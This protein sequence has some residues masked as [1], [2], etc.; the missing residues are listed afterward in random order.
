MK[1]LLKGT[2]TLAIATIVG[3][4][5]LQAATND[6]T[7]EVKSKK[8]SKQTTKG[9]YGITYT[10]DNASYTDQAWPLVE[11]SLDYKQSNYSYSLPTYQIVRQFGVSMGVVYWIN[12]AENY[13]YW[14]NTVTGESGRTAP[15]KSYGVGYQD[16]I[17]NPNFA[18]T[19]KGSETGPGSISQDWNGNLV[20]MWNEGLG[21]GKTSG[22]HFVQGYA[23][24]KSATE[25]GKLMDFIPKLSRLN[26]TGRENYPFY[27]RIV[28]G[29]SP[30]TLKGGAGFTAP[31][32]QMETYYTK[33][34]PSSKVPNPNYPADEVTWNN[35]YDYHKANTSI[36]KQPTDFLGVSGDLWG[37]GVLQGATVNDIGRSAYTSGWSTGQVFHV[38]NNIAFGNMFADGQYTNWYLNYY[39]TVGNR[40][41]PGYQIWPNYGCWE[42]EGT[43]NQYIPRQYA[44]DN[45]ATEYYFMESD[46][47][48]YFWSVPYSGLAE[49]DIT[50]RGTYKWHGYVDDLNYGKYATY[51]TNDKE[52]QPSDM[53]SSPEVDS[54]KGTRIMINNYW[55]QWMPFDISSTDANANKRNGSIMIQYTKYTDS[56]GN[57]PMSTTSAPVFTGDPTRNYT[58]VGYTYGYANANKVPTANFPVQ[59]ANTT[60]N[61]W[62]ELERVNDNVFA[63]YTHV[64]GRGFSKTFITAVKPNNAVSNLKVAQSWNANGDPVHTLTWT[65]QAGDRATMHTYEV[66]YRKK[67]GSTYEDKKTI[68]GASRDV[69]NFAGKAHVKYNGAT[70]STTTSSGNR[71]K[72]M[73]NKAFYNS[74]TAES[75]KFE[76]VAPRGDNGDGTKYERTYEYMVIP[77]YDAS[78]HRGTEATT[79]IVTAPAPSK[80]YGNLYQ[81]T[82]KNA[83]GETLYGFSI[84]LDPYFLPGALGST[85]AKRLII[86]SAGGYEGSD[87]LKDAMSVTL[88]D[89]TPLTP[90][91]GI[92]FQ[93]KTDGTTQTHGAYALSIDITGKVGA[94]GKLP[95]II[96]HNVNPDL[97]FQLAAHIESTSTY[98]YSG[99]GNLSTTLYVPEP[100]LTI[101][102]AGFYKLAGDYGTLTE[103][104][105]MPIG[106]FRRIDPATNTLDMNPTNPV[107][108]NNANYY[109]TNGGA[110][111]PILVT[112]EVLG[113]LNANGEYENNG[114]RVGYIIRVFDKDAEGKDVK[115]NIPGDCNFQVDAGGWST[116]YS[117]VH[118]VMCDIVGLKVDYTTEK[119]ED[120]RDRK[121]Y[122]P[123]AKTYKVEVELEYYRD[124]DKDGNFQNDLFVNRKYYTEL[125]V[126]T[127]TLPELG[128][129][130]A[131]SS[132][133]LGALY[134]RGG[135]HFYYDNA[136][137]N[138]YYPYYYDAA[139]LFNW[140]EY[141]SLNRY[142]GYYGKS[143]AV[144][145]GHYEN[146][147]H[148]P[149]TWV[150]Y[151][152]GSILTDAE[153]ESL[154]SS[155]ETLTNG[156]IEYNGTNNW[157]AQAIEYS[158]V[159]MLVHY[160]HG[161]NTPLASD[162]T[163]VSEIKFDV[164]LT[165]EYPI[166]N[167]TNSF[168][169]II[170]A[171][172]PNEYSISNGEMNVM[173]VP[174]PLTNMYVNNTTVTTGVEGI[175]T[176][177][178]GGWQLYPNPVGS[179]FTLHAPMII[180][181]VQI[182]SMDGQLV[183]VVKDVKDTTVKINVDELP[184]G[185]YIVN[186]LGVAKMM[187]KM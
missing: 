86:T 126:G 13:I 169:G 162:E 130:N 45:A 94:D 18:F 157:S 183:K 143:K 60:V 39:L 146:V 139:M 107:T 70:D 136:T 21:W 78:S 122:N 54:I 33:Y 87:K 150:Q 90:L 59:F 74:Y 82:E 168:A 166:I 172:N 24:Y 3:I 84:R 31:F 25:Y 135:S 114:W 1:K 115:I 118:N 12:P 28:E 182:F 41:Y 77:V 128:V 89:G 4:P 26:D 32:D 96:W 164:T 104:E 95:S 23:V 37:K 109:G 62:N 145:Y 153:V 175:I 141:N 108:L 120:G 75:C 2:L 65:P 30:G 181:D 155:N 184:Q 14:W 44:Y 99:T 177:A 142:M 49:Y 106:S 151:H 40:N 56:N 158:Q 7:I 8:F 29:A 48:E 148:N 159:P 127:T 64:P 85:E 27:K 46:V 144:C 149:D 92:T 116:V 125:K 171:E 20:H 34:N 100:K 101:P 112:D 180:G 73:P 147:E 80:I 42:G 173:T 15:T 123:T 58:P 160:V 154:N 98:Q 66:W 102:D 103:N 174:T 43:S 133:V 170:I 161:A 5:Q 72:V 134:Q 119:G 132:A 76:F 69:W 61:S 50:D 11:G 51:L 121:R 110:L 83:N 36:T 187:I 91:D 111:S 63:L 152:A 55:L 117:N 57:N 68:D 185:V 71:S 97:E 165:A 105:D 163:A 81:V 22:T 167:Y 53:F 186:T 67:K 140:D 129:K 137:S 179:A 52:R 93:T 6:Y 47:L 16:G 17:N 35:N 124:K 19:F 138:G 79:S 176:N 156:A 88:A 10:E 113:T 178:C 131:T 9:F 38:R